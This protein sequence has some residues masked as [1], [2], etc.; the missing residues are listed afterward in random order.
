L[1]VGD[2]LT[3]LVQDDAARLRSSQ[4]FTL[5]PDATKLQSRVLREAS[6]DVLDLRLVE[7]GR[8]RTLLESHALRVVGICETETDENFERAGRD[9]ALVG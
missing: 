2:G 5:G 4:P 9:T 3:E 6:L 7:V 1:Q 8:A